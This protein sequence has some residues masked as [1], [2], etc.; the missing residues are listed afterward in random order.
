MTAA[1][2]L[3]LAGIWLSRGTVRA[4]I[5]LMLGVGLL[6]V[7]FPALLGGYAARY[8]VPAGGPMVAAGVLGA[9]AIARKREQFP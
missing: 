6:L 8:T 3:A 9:W 5:V 7:V 2:V 4:G 1:L